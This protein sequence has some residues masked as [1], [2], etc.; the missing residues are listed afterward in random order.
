MSDVKQVLS[1]M[2][3]DSQKGPLARPLLIARTIA[4]VTAVAG[5]MPT[6]YQYYQSW[7]H[8]IPYSEVPH[9]LSQ[10][11]MFVANID[12]TPT[13]K[14]LTAANGTRIDAAACP[15]TGDISVRIVAPGNSAYHQWVAFKQLQ[16][17]AI[18]KTTW[19][20]MIVSTAHA[21]APASQ[22]KPVQLA[23]APAAPAGSQ[24]VCQ[25]LQP[26]A[27]VVR[28]VNEGGK[29]FRETI[30]AIHGKTEKRDEVPCN[31]QC[32]PPSKG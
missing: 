31:T 4:I 29:C 26:K 16:K 27:M 6:A 17:T 24:V 28:I 14:A 21:E 2:N 7:Q 3:E 22:S 9:R 8:D 11:E 23:Q 13:Y 19:L 30:S 5:A 18:A 12:C 10:Y 32:P 25:A 1:V 15:K 20:D